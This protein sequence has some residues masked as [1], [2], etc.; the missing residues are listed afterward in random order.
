[1][2]DNTPAPEVNAREKFICPACGGEAVWDARKQKLV[3]PFCGTESTAALP[4]AGTL[5]GHDLAQALTAMLKAPLA[6][7]HDARR[8]VR[9]QSCNAISV[10]DASRQAQRCEFC[11]SAQLVPYADEGVVVRPEGVLP[12]A[13]AE[14]GARD[15]IRAWYGKLWLA[16]GA[17][18]RRAL[19][20]TVKGVY[21]PYWTFD[22]DVDAAWTA[23]R[24]H[25]YWT[26]ET[27]YEKGEMR[28]RQVQQV[29]WE[30][31]AGRLAHHFDDE[32][33][34]ASVGVHPAL[35]RGIEPFPMNALKPYDAGYVSGWVVERYR[36]D[37]ADAA[38]RAR[39]AMDAETRGLCG[40]AVGGDTYRNLDV[41]AQY[42]AQTF[43]H[44]LAPVW[45]LTYTFGAK[46]F[47]CAINGV[48]GAI[49]GEYPKSPWK[50]ALIV[51]AVIVALVVF[52]SLGGHR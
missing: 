3:C 43:K 40:T 5:A 26:T 37:L 35:V 10:L 31:A 11:G 25:Y 45:L 24:G 16:P 28:T 18:K 33:V 2:P 49:Q 38:T 34:C 46:S 7:V 1:M 8:M 36:I 29:R 41:Q 47:Q 50:I 13:L 19:T 4:A 20:D 48:S 14:D 6:P 21:L 30:P 32:L 52:A 17:L 42:S 23:E 15:R 51:V 12:F 27:Y 39:A 22:A 44:V 9:C